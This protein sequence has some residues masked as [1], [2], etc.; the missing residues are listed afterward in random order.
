MPSPYLHPCAIFAPMCDAFQI[1]PE[2]HNSADQ[3]ISKFFFLCLC[4]IVWFSTHDCLPGLGSE[5]TCTIIYCV[6]SVVASLMV[7]SK[8]D[9]ILPFWLLI[10][11]S[12]HHHSRV[13]H[14]F[15]VRS[16]SLG[17]TWATEL[18]ESIVQSFL[19]NPLVARHW[20]RSFCVSWNMNWLI[21]VH[22]SWERGKEQRRCREEGELVRN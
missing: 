7:I 21:F 19:E 4:L 11:V 1:Q 3:G 9:H 13:Y 18:V 2:L 15:E 16:W 12:E 6:L 5:V 22:F 20:K 17:L 14:L 10:R 8:L